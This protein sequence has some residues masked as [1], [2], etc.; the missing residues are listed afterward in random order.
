MSLPTLS[1]T[2]RKGRDMT[3]PPDRVA[4]IGVGRMGAPVARRLRAAGFD[5]TVC[6]SSATARAPFAD[7]G[8]RVAARPAD[9]GEA[10]VIVVLVAT[11]GQVR[12]VVTGPGGIITGVRPGRE[13]LVVVMSTAGRDLVVSLHGE[14][15]GCGV[16]LVDAPVSGGPGRAE[17]GTLTVMV[18]GSQHE[19]EKARPVL[20]SIGNR[21][22]P[23]GPVGG[24]QVAKLVNNLICAANVAVTGEAYRLA[25]ENGL[26]MSGISEVL[27][28]STGRNFLTQGPAEAAAYFA[29][30]AAS[31]GGFDSVTS[32][33]RKDIGLGLE[34][35]SAAAG[36]YPVIRNLA[37]LFD[38][39]GDETYRNWGAIAAADSSALSRTPKQ[40]TDMR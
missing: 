29:R 15:V 13:P 9:C 36:S 32:I 24:A 14:L 34:L 6:D 38:S 16:P 11:P 23:C 10:D 5:L 40:E 37:A 12:D 3:P 33:L 19:V 35:A 2:V 22:I 25:L 4:I 21:V 28:V 26:S 20:E 27:D 39:L 8:T 1:S 18:G 17:E 7:S 31:P 30:W